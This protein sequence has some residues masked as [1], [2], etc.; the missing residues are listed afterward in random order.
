MISREIIF[1]GIDVS[2]LSVSE[3]ELTA[4]LLVKGETNLSLIS[5]IRSEMEKSVDCKMS[6]I[7]IP[8]KYSENTVELCGVCTVKSENLKR[9][10]GN[11]REAFLFAVTLGNKVERHLLRLSRLSVSEHFIADA[12]AS[13]YAEAAADKAQELLDSKAKTKNRFS[14]GYGDVP[15]EIQKDVLYCLNAERLLGI[16]LTDTL[17][18]KPQ[19]SITAIVGIENE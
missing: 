7:R 3:R 15:L 12:I 5:E 19:K 9:V 18:M 2:E 10:L 4:R 13:A 6:A 8:L 14:P 16:T 17:L 1:K 11:S